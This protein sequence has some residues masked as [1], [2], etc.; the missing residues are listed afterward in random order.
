MNRVDFEKYKKEKLE[1][2]KEIRRLDYKIV[3][4]S[5]QLYNLSNRSKAVE[6]KSMAKE[7]DEK[8]YKLIDSIDKSEKTKKI[9]TKQIFSKFE[10][11]KKDLLKEIENLQQRCNNLKDQLIVSKI[12]LNKIH[13]VYFDVLQIEPVIN[14][15]EIENQNINQIIELNNENENI[16]KINEDPEN[17]IQKSTQQDIFDIPKQRV[18]D[19]ENLLKYMHTISQNYRNEIEE[20][21]NDYINKYDILTDSTFMQNKFNNVRENFIVK[22][23]N[24]IIKFKKD[25]NLDEIN[26]KVQNLLENNKNIEIE[27]QNLLND[28][29][30][31]KEK[32]EKLQDVYLVHSYA[33]KIL[34]EFILHQVNEE[35]NIRKSKI[36]EDIAIFKKIQKITYDE[37]IRHII[38]VSKWTKVMESKLKYQRLKENDF[39]TII[40]AIRQTENTCNINYENITNQI[41]KLCEAYTKLEEIENVNNL[42]KQILDQNIETSDILKEGINVI[43]K[44]YLKIP[45]IGRKVANILNSNA[46]NA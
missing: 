7:N 22:F 36:N 28:T 13:D 23:N 9:L 27:K 21:I 15:I 20:K 40:Y 41:L 24:V 25:E 8:I 38:E 6:T 32:I 19:F 45:F 29:Q 30:V 42:N 16:E 14:Y 33:R 2:D 17:V 10:I 37:R 26:N 4:E 46:L 3:E 12:A 43:K 39:Q 31:M 11:I 1:Y 35:K 34:D 5:V 44:K 18:I